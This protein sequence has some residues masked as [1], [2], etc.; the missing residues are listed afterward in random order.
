MKFYVSFINSLCVI[1]QKSFFLPTIE[2]DS[3]EDNLYNMKLCNCNMG[4]M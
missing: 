2:T 3:A 1:V 4:A